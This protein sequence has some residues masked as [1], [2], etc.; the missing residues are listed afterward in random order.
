MS[1]GNTSDEI[2]AIERRLSLMLVINVALSAAML[3]WWHDLS[4]YLADPIR[5]ATWENIGP[6]TGTFEYPFVMLWVLPLVA[7]GIAWTLRM[8]GSRR[9]ALW[10]ASFP[11]FYLGTLV[12]CFYIAPRLM[13]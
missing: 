12:A 4:R 13:L 11:V 6:N 1:E 10:I 9:K 3:L 2:A 8:A 5:W 7:F